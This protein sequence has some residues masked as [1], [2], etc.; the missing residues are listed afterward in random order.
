MSNPGEVKLFNVGI[1]GQ[2]VRHL[3][4][5]KRSFPCRGIESIPSGVWGFCDMCACVERL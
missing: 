2:Y 5:M 1:V 4:G 3:G